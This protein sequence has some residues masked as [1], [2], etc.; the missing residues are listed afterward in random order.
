MWYFVIAII[1]MFVTFLIMYAYYIKYIRYRSYLDYYEENSVF[2]PVFAGLLW[3]S[4]LIGGIC[5]LIY[6]KWLKKHYQRFIKWLADKLF[7]DI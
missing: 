3:P 2:A 5:Y 7:P 4:V 1:T 6:K